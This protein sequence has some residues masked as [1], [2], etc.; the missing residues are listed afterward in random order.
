MKNITVKEIIEVTKGTLIYGNEEEICQTFSRNTNE[1]NEN[2]IYIGFKG[3]K[4]DGSK[5]YEEALNKGAKGCILNK[6]LDMEIKR[7]ENKFVI[8]VE[9]TIEAVGKI[10]QL[11]RE[12][13]QIPVIAITGSVGKTSTKDIIYSV[14]SQKYNTL[15]TQGNMNNH[16]GLPM[17]ILKLQN[18]EAIVVEMGM[19]HIGEIKYLSN[20]AKPDIA[21][22]T[23]IGTAHIGNLGSRENILKAKLEILE[24]LNEKGY[25]IIN[26]DNDLLNKWNK[27][28]KTYKVITYGIKNKSQYNIEN[29]EYTEK[30]STY[31]LIDRTLDK[32]KD[33]NE[34]IKVPTGGEAFI[35]NSLAAISVGKTLG[36]TMQ[37]IKTGIENFELS[38]MRLD[39]QKTQYG[40]TIINDCYNANY[41]SMKSAI[42]YLIN[43]E[44]K[45]KIAV[46]GDMLELGQFSKKLHEKVGE[47]VAKNK[48]NILITV[49]NESKNIAEIARQNGV[50]HVYTFDKNEEAI[51]KLKK[52]LAKD[53][54]VLIKASNSMNF[55]QM[56][57]ELTKDK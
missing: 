11:K 1:I 43:I 32:N 19:N 25:L 12:K 57:E 51:E 35:Y 50:E 33:N 30:G 42:E 22:I 8:Q 21:V 34:K 5:F 40:Y 52:I 36:L 17:T 48:I 44:G 27:E 41:D 53:D 38:K 56:V 16:I 7:I 23:N 4:F 6:N 45:R 20:I 14:I 46:L 28:N 31:N 26:N 10:A 15:K 3:E 29:I 13:Y 2:D 49:G 37:E 9:D 18:H 55:K 39:V 54:I 24:A 47:E